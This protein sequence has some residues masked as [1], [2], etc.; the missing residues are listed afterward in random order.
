MAVRA[1]LGAL[2]R[3]RRLQLRL[4]QRQ[5]ATRAGVSLA[6]WQTVE[7]AA[8]ET[9]FQELTLSRIA[10]A[11]DLPL[12]QVFEAGGQSLPA[13]TSVPGARGAVTDDRAPVDAEALTRQLVQLLL[14]L[15]QQS[16]DDFLLVY[17]VAYEL[18]ERLSRGGSDVRH[19]GHAHTP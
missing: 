14:E 11:L 5:A 6:T 1:R 12:E 17:H 7:R 15:Q 13:A 2:V 8:G 18:A 19:E 9:A 16:E 10:H 3:R 4:T